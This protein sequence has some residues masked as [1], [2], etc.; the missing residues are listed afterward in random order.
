MS[1]NAEEIKIRKKKKEDM[2][3]MKE[4]LKLSKNGDI[5]NWV[6]CKFLKCVIGADN[7]KM[8]CFRK[9]LSD[10]VTNSD[11][12]FMLLILENNYD[13]WMEEARRVAERKGREE[14]E[15]DGEEQDSLPE[16]LYTN[17]GNSKVEGKGSSRRFQGWS[18]KGYVRFNRMHELV[19]YD[20][21]RR[22]DFEAQLRKAMEEQN[23]KSSGND[24]SDEEDEE[25]LFPANDWKNVRKPLPIGPEEEDGSEGIGEDGSENEEEATPET[26]G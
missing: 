14:E 17:S 8:N 16:A 12:G 13:R 2:P 24:D 3:S 9:P 15:E 5:Y 23:A 22:A 25:E 4:I 21:A 11:E 7:W 19:R 20:R 10:F 26:E 6:C 1:T 18:R